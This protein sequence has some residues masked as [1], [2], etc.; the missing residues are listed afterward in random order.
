MVFIN[1]LFYSPCLINSFTYL[2]TYVTDSSI[3]LVVYWVGQ[4][5]G[6]GRTDGHHAI[7]NRNTA[8]CTKVHR[9]VKR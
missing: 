6:D 8:L 5:N 3:R 2:L 1:I 4:F 7:A 9:A